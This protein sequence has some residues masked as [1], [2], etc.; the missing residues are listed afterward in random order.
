MIK[1]LYENSKLKIKSDFE[2]LFIIETNFHIKYFIIDNCKKN[3][4]RLVQDVVNNK[5]ISFPCFEFKIKNENENIK[6]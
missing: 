4:L 5:I 1:T 6:N 3:H 2:K